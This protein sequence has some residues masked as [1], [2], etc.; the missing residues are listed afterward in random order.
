MIILIGLAF[1]L[2]FLITLGIVDM[3]QSKDGE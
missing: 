1:I 3:A 2:V